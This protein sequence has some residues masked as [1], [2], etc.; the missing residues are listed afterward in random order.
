MPEVLALAE[1]CFLA[2]L[3]DATELRVRRSPVV[4]DTDEI[5]RPVLEHI[6]EHGLVQAE[7][8]TSTDPAWMFGRVESALYLQPN[9]AR[10]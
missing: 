10:H 4:R 9:L 3:G 6:S 5:Y 1:D 2:A 8:S 7:T